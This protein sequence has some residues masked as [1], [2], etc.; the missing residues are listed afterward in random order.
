MSA[1]ADPERIKRRVEEDW[2]Y[3][4]PIV[5]GISA[6]DGSAPIDGRL[7]E[8][9]FGPFDKGG[10]PITLLWELNYAIQRQR[11]QL[12]RAIEDAQG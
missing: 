10:M 3:W 12:R 7:L 9:I 1:L 4:S 5:A 6:W 8:A 11:E 2:L